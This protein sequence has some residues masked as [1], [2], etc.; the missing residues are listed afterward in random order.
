MSSYKHI[1]DKHNKKVVAMTPSTGVSQEVSESTSEVDPTD[2][3]QTIEEDKELAVDRSNVIIDT[4]TVDDNEEA[5]ADIDAE[6]SE[7]KSTLEEYKIKLEELRK[8][9]DRVEKKIFE[10]RMK[11]NQSTGG[12][13]VTGAE[14]RT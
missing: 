4:A 1:R 13:E 12:L 10:A 2:Y 11:L 7:T 5:P 9:T 6:I 3:L 14:M 8:I